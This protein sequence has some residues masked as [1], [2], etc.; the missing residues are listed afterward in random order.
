MKKK[1]RIAQLLRYYKEH[2]R[3]ARYTLERLE[4]HR[5]FINYLPATKNRQKHDQM[6]II[7]KI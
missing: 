4:E 1:L 3:Q 5:V 7:T 6:V 2:M